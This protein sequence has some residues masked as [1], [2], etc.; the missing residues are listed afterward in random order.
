MPRTSKANAYLVPNSLICLLLF[1]ISLL[2]SISWN[3]GVLGLPGVNRSL[4]ALQCQPFLIIKIIQHEQLNQTY[5]KSINSLAFNISLF[6]SHFISIYTQSF[7]TVFFFVFFILFI[8]YLVYSQNRSVHKRCYS[9]L[10]LQ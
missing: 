10:F 4:T 9:I 8:S 6:H 3:C 5:R 7:P 2:L 1:S